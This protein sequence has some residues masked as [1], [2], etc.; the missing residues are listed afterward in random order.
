VSDPREPPH[1]CSEFDRLG[2]HLVETAQE[3]SERLDDLKKTNDLLRDYA[4]AWREL[5]HEARDERDKA[6][7]DAGKLEAQLDAANETIA[8]LREELAEAKAVT[9]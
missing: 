9:P 7:R 1:Q 2:K 5:C 3:F 4:G 8:A 6:E